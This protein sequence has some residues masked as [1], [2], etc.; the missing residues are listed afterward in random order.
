MKKQKHF[1]TEDNQVYEPEK[2]KKVTEHLEVCNPSMVL[3]T[4]FNRDKIKVDTNYDFERK[5]LKIN[6][7]LRVY[8]RV[9]RRKARRRRRKKVIK[10]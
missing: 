7:K 1:F 2:D 3:V 10:W 6:V 5:M 8:S 4:N 9:Y